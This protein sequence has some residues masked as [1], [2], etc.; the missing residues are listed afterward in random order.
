MRRRLLLLSQERSGYSIISKYRCLCGEGF[1]EEDDDKTPGHRDKMATL[2]CPN[3]SRKYEI[4]YKNEL[5]WSIQSKSQQ[6]NLRKEKTK[7]YDCFIDNKEKAM[8][9]Y[10]L[11]T[12]EAS[13]AL[14]KDLYIDLRTKV[15]AWSEIT[16]Q[17]P[18]ARMGYVGQHLVSVVTGFPGGKSGARGY[19]LVMDNGTYGEIKTCYRVDQLGSCSDCGAVVSSLESVCAACGSKNIN[20]KDD[21]K[22]LITINN[23]TEFAEVIEPKAYYFV[24]FEFADLS[25]PSNNDIEASIWEVNPLNK[26]FAFCMVDY[27][28][29]IRAKSKSKAPFNMWPHEFKFALTKPQ[30]IYRA[31]IKSNGN[32]ETII[33]PTLG[34][35]FTDEL[36]P[37]TEYSRATTITIDSALRVLSRLTGRRFYSKSKRDC[38]EYI[39][40]LRIKNHI[41]N[42]VLCD[43]FA[44]EIYLPL[45]C[46]VK[47]A[48]P[49]DIISKYS[50]LQ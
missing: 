11:G 49:R 2:Q 38:L 16:N 17:T 22:W 50:E 31:M 37:L 27:Y 9:D 43:M 41:P 19:D 32:I 30:L 7:I 8:I 28:L 40:N 15:N 42:D 26:G 6:K 1:I 13:E 46:P 5:C 44:E 12:V 4:K 23:D 18:Q 24:L 25:D 14:I 45:I 33:F 34:N 48:I 10:K 20:R 36:E 3:C 29:N 35:G 47:K 21:S 39:E